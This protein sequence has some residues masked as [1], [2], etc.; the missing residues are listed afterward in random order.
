M[1]AKKNPKANLESFSKIFMLLGLVLA[2][3]ISYAAI[4]M[5]SKEAE[6]T[7]QAEDNRKLNNEE[8]IPETE[9]KIEDI[10]PENLPP[11]PPVI[12][13]IRVVE[14][15][16]KIEEVVVESTETNE[17]Q[18]V[19]IH[20]IKEEEVEEDVVEDVPFN[21]IEDVPVYPGC[22]GDKEALKKCFSEKVKDFITSK[23][24]TDL[25]NEVGLEPGKYKISVGFKVDKTGS[26]TNIQARAPHKRLE[27]E[28][29]RVTGLLPKLAPG[30]QR[31]RPVSVP[32]NLPITFMVE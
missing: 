32:Y 16:K 3:L 7:A 13:D 20:N 17:K 24:N 19:V 18:A 25:T 10:K 6:T 28:A 15:N 23:F 2:L 22:K 5:K 29:I 14:D 8:D 27:A 26:I 4:E 30:K 12:E 31:G 11:P 9:Q 1:E 21:I